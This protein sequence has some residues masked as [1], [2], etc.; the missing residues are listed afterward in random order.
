MSGV[1][2]QRSGGH[3]RK[4]LEQH[5][6]DATLRADRHSPY[7]QPRPRALELD[8]GALNVHGWPGVTEAAYL[9]DVTKATI[10]NWMKAGKI[11][12]PSMQI[13]AGMPTMA[14]LDAVDD[15]DE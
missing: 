5:R 7:S 9:C 6:K 1:R 2:G 3:N 14:E 10:F 4:S 13:E 8:R 15:E 12:P 11:P